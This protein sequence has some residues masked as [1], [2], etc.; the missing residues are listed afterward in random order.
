MQGFLMTRPARDTTPVVPRGGFFH[1]I[2]LW[3]LSLL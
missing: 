3:S 1:L 2:K